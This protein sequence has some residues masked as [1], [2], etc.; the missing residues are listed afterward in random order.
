M[1]EA[2]SRGSDGMRSEIRAAYLPS[3]NKAHIPLISLTG[4]W[5]A[6]QWIRKE[7]LDLA[8]AYRETVSNR[9]FVLPAA[10]S[11][12]RPEHCR[13][14]NR[15]FATDRARKNRPDGEIT[16]RCRSMRRMIAHSGTQ[17]NTWQPADH[18]TG[19]HA[20]LRSNFL[21]AR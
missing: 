7:M 3:F 13:R 14:A 12:I 6:W 1:Q 17:P 11:A 2:E 16:V 20:S 9:E 18:S 19:I 21:P 8:T 10:L 5:E 4:G 15:S